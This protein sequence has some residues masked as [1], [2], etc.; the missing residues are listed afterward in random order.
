MNPPNE[1]TT[2]QRI[3]AG[4]GTIAAATLMT[5]PALAQSTPTAPASNRCAPVQGGIGGPINTPAAQAVPPSQQGI[6]SYSSSSDVAAIPGSTNS[7]PNQSES[8]ANQRDRTAGLQDRAASAQRDRR[9]PTANIGS[10]DL[11]T[12]RQF[13]ANNRSAAIAY[14]ANG[15]AGTSGHEA[16]MNLDAVREVN[17]RPAVPLANSPMTS[18]SSSNLSAAPLPT[19]CVP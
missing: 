17:L 11:F 4:F 14:R 2:L 10:S 19:E 1:M 5:L 18:S 8:Y 12:R 6:A 9:N 13:D 7:Y 16:K 15:P 3:L